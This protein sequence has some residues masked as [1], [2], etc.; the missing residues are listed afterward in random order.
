M[1]KEKHALDQVLCG[2]RDHRVMMSFRGWCV[3][4]G[5][6]EYELSVFV[7]EKRIPLKYEARSLRKDVGEAFASE[8]AI[9]ETRGIGFMAFAELPED[10]LTGTLSLTAE[11][12]GRKLLLGSY[13]PEEVRKLAETN[14]MA[15]AIDR[16][17]MDENRMII[18]G[19]V[20]SLTGSEL[21]YTLFGSDGTAIPM[22]LKKTAR[23]DINRSF[24]GEPYRCMAGFSIE[25]EGKKNGLY[26]LEAGDGEHQI[27]IPVSGKEIAKA[28]QKKQ[29][30]YQSAGEIIRSTGWKDVGSD[31]KTLFR[32]GPS[33]LK[34]VWAERYTNEFHQYERWFRAQAPGEETLRAQREERFP[35]M[36]KISIIV[37]AYHT[38]ELFLKQMV[39]SVRS[40]SYENWEL[41]IADGG[42]D[43]PAVGRFLEPLLKED[44]RIRYRKLEEN[45]GISGNTNEAAAMAE[46]D[47]LAL[48]DHDDVLTPD[49]LYEVV[50]A[51]NQN[52]DADVFYTD[53]DKTS[54]DLS[55]FYDPHFKSDFNRDLLRSNNYI[56][57]F[58]VASMEVVKKAGLFD[59]EYDGSQ[60]Y[61]FILR[62]TEAAK[63]VVHIPKIL[64]HWRVHNASTAA[65]SE[66]KMYCFEAGRK[67][68]AAHLGRC[69]LEAEVAMFPEH[70]GYYQ[71]HY[72][73][74]GQPFVSIIIPNKDEK[75]S[76]ET[77]IRSIRDKTEYENY[78]I[79][80]VENNSTTEEIF[81]YYRE[82]S[83]DEKIRVLYWKEGFNYS[84]LNNFGVRESRGDYLLFLNNDTEVLSGDWLTVMT[85]DCQ[86]EN[87]GMVGVKLCYPDMTLQHCGVMLGLGGVAGHIFTSYPGEYMGCF[88]RAQLQQ[89]VSAV[90]A[91]CMMVRRS[92]Y[93][94]V[95]GFEEALAVAFND[96]DF[97]LKVREK[98]YDI[99]YEPLV[100]LKHYESK[101]R[102]REDTAEKQLRFQSEVDYMQEKWKTVLEKGDPYYSRNML[103]EG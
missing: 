51:A 24:L 22:K 16:M 19:W 60:D 10:G 102:G 62:C 86:R 81:E 15:Y 47:F 89:D 39:D 42:A 33:A 45:K 66:N 57:H 55:T 36:P 96:V 72:R 52:P 5:T 101:S 34:E 73:L 26:T 83:R 48:L 49:A 30:K 99:L 1:I 4:D 54:R 56:C 80:I 31:L 8:G 9:E 88:G 27:R 7:D 58:F 63:Q 87:I 14:G 70:L 98:G 18:S 32:K 17:D 77:C 3:M 41:C 46:G 25:F 13:S 82:L 76:L 84:A 61:D 100:C 37:P 35:R 44:P 50:R 53:E 71:V 85:A 59:P 78:E 6:D 94:E 29:R 38:P 93:E 92:V 23:P 11:Q 67:A 90:T 75:E 97:C 21:S 2:I 12:N 20:I 65:D 43:D 79:I 95:G 74:T 69:G 68:V 91:A 40:Q 103:M 64:Y 28:A